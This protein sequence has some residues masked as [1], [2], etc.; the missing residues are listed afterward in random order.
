[1]K[2]TDSGRKVGFFFWI[3]ERRSVVLLETPVPKCPRTQKLLV[4]PLQRAMVRI[5]K[6]S[7]AE[8]PNY[9]Y[10]KIPKMLPNKFPRPN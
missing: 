5:R 3:G 7:P 6:R 9:Y 1:M 8:H 4:T 10:F 2:D